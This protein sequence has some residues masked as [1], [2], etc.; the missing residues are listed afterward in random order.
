MPWNGNRYK[1]RW[2]RH[3]NKESGRRGYRSIEF[4]CCARL[5]VHFNISSLYNCRPIMM[6]VMML[7]FDDNNFCVPIA[8]MASMMV[9]TLHQDWTT[10]Q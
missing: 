5:F 1:K 10:K 6:M 9:F 2:Y 4:H 3:R 7:L 8:T